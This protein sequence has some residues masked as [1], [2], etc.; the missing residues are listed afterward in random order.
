[1]FQPLKR[2]EELHTDGISTE[3]FFKG[4]TSSDKY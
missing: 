1:M 2:Q 4:K 3:S